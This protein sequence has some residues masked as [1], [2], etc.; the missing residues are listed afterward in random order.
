[1]P[2]DLRRDL[3]VLANLPPI[4]GLYWLILVGC[5]SLGET[6]ADL[7]SHGLKWGYVWSSA[8]LLVLFGGAIGFE[9]YGRGAKLARYWCAVAATAMVGTTLADLTSRTLGLGYFK[10]SALM[11]ALFATVFGTWKRAHGRRESSELHYWSAILVISVM[12][13]TLG[14]F[15]SNDT[16]LGFGWTSVV[17]IAALGA[18]LFALYRASWRKEPLYWLIVVLTSTFGAA[19]GDYLTKEEGL[20]MGPFKGTALL[21]AVLIVILAFVARRMRATSD[22]AA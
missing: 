20:N 8:L 5:C 10:A 2:Q 13:T 16:P 12:G 14:D 17:L 19:S 6:A 3:P 21:A 7:L 1:M 22:L 9:V 4:N 15:L 11:I 18:L